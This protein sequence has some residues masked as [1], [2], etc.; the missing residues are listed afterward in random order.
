M[1]KRERVGRGRIGDLSAAA[2]HLLHEH[3]HH[4]REQIH[5]W[6]PP[7]RSDTDRTGTGSSPQPV[8]SSPELHRV[9]PT[10]PTTEFPGQPDSATD[11][12]APRIP[13]TPRVTTSKTVVRKDVWVRVPHSAPWAT[14]VR[15][16]RSAWWC[17]V[18]SSGGA[19]PRPRPGACPR[20]PFCWGCDLLFGSGWLWVSVASAGVD[21]CAPVLG[22]AASGRC[23]RIRSSL[24]HPVREIWRCGGRCVF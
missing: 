14:H 22:G 6:H 18:L 7:S 5:S 1:R 17:L 8:R 2:K 24:T 4:L 10:I 3:H 19:T 23:C 21:S 16:N 15:G 20:T 11:T 13:Q 12:N 9:R